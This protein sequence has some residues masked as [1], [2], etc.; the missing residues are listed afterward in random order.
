MASWTF[1]PWVAGSTLIQRCDTL[2]RASF[3]VLAW[4]SSC[5]WAL[6]RL[7][8]MALFSSGARPAVSVATCAHA[9][10]DRSDQPQR[11]RTKQGEVN[12]KN[13]SIILAHFTGRGLAATEHER[14]CAF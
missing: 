14:G 8:T 7:A 1:C 2:P 9:P 11:A 10:P 5:W 13:L 6:A 4:G 3:W 12:F